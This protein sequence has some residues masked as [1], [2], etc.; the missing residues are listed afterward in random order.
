[1]AEVFTFPEGSAYLWT[2]NSTTSALL[3]FVRGVTV[4]PKV[5]RHDYR[6][7]FATT[8]TYTE[9]QRRADL[10]ISQAYSDPTAI[11]FLQNAGGGAVHCHLKH[12][13]GGNNG[14]AG[15]FLYTGSLRDMN[16]NETGP[17]EIGVSFNGTFD[18][19]SA[20]P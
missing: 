15:I 13:I 8:W 9:I 7:P 6:A 20:Y 4:S 14:S 18:T 17:G 5:D 1:M 12:I 2:G 11:R 10:T 19:F 3:V 16:I